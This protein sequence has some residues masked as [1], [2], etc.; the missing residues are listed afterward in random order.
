[1]SNGVRVTGLRKFV[2]NLERLGVSVEDMKEVMARVSAPIVSKA[3]ALTPVRSGRL[4]ESVR[5][6]KA[7]NK[8]VIR[9][10]TKATDYASFVEFGSIH[11]TATHMV[12]DS[13]MG[14]EPQTAASLNHELQGLIRKYGLN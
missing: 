9:A 2:R 14:S 6:S 11:N 4:Q 10:G 13:I 1:M 7:K 12:R 3:K 5:S 8:A